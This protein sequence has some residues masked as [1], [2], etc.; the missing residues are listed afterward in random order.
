MNAITN[1][2][3]NFQGLSKPQSRKKMTDEEVLKEY[4]KEATQYLAKGGERMVPE[5]GKYTPYSVFVEVKG[6]SNIARVAIEHDPLDPKTQRLINIGVYKN[7]SN[8]IYSRYP[9]SGT[10]KEILEYLKSKKS[11]DEIYNHIIELSD[12]VN[13]KEY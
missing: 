10:K 9:I 12:K 2:K 1:N 13:K 7:G 3:I 5:N 4:I 11:Q 8:K 6:T